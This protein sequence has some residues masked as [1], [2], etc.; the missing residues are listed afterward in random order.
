MKKATIADVAQ[1]ANVS[2][3]TVSQ[4]LN[5]RFD[6]MAEN[7]KQRIEDA[8]K[9]LDYRPNI[10]ARSLKQKSTMTIGVIVANILHNFSTQVIR[11][12]ED[13]CHL[14]DFHLIVCNA[15][16]D[17]EKEKRYIDMLRAK[18]VDGII[19]FP[20]GDNVELYEEMV[21]EKYPVIFVD[22][23]VPEVSIP[24]VM[25]DNENAAGLAVQHFIEKGYERIGIITNVIRNVSPRM[26]RITGYKKALQSNGIPI[27]EEYIKKLEINK[28]Q[29]GLEE[30][31]SLEEPIQA[32][33]AGN[34]LTL[35]EILKYVKKQG[36]RIPADLAI[37]GIDDV[38]F[39]S[40][41][42]PA[43]T[44]VEQPSF[45][46][47]KKAA[48]LLLSKIQKKDVEEEQANYRLEPRLIVRNSC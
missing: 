35:M 21:D 24:S 1:H 13:M 22:R 27:K 43:L 34:D 29:A 37:I 11:S 16:D 3:S 14:Y 38:S 30:M 44:I 15:D 5:K 9:E 18:Q 8:I 45:E 2:K 25:L 41:Y 6:Y 4:Y 32:I 42:E 48:E 46:I 7:T 28:I 39:A 33:L 17:P 26:E 12:I 19:L 10:V 40:F 36:L 31:L 20:T 47:G 23:I